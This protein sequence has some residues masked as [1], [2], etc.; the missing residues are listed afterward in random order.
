MT[1]V[2]LAIVLCRGVR[3]IAVFAEV[4]NR[5]LIV[6]Y[7][8]YASVPN[9]I[10]E[11]LLQ[12]GLYRHGTHDAQSAVLLAMVSVNDRALMRRLSSDDVVPGHVETVAS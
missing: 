3:F 8:S 12:H 7:E 4:V 9:G 1:G 11:G 5:C 2:V 10:Y 6:W